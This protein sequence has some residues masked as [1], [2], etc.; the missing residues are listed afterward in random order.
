MMI[1]TLQRVQK[2]ASDQSKLKIGYLKP[3]QL[4]QNA[5]LAPWGLYVETPP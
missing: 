5:T 3:M 4:E 1:Y 2:H